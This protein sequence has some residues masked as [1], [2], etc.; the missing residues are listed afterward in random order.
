MGD[1]QHMWAS[2][3][4]VMMVRNMLIREEFSPRRLI[5]CSGLPGA[6]LRQDHDIKFG[7][8]LSLFGTLSMQVSFAASSLKV[9]IKDTEWK[10]GRPDILVR[11]PG[12]QSVKLPSESDSVF[13]EL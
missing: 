11:L 6:W 3:E 9:V 10:S 7:P 4:W 8:C 5:L 12:R 2:A 13:I 1:G